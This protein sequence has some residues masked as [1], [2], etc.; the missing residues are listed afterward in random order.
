MCENTENGILK[1]IQTAY[2]QPIKWSALSVPDVEHMLLLTR[3]QV[4]VL[5]HYHTRLSA[6]ITNDTTTAAKKIIT[7]Q[8]RLPTVVQ[9]GHSRGEYYGI[10]WAGVGW[11]MSSEHV[12]VLR[13]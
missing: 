13:D 3:L 10:L 1:I 4:P 12:R 11:D 7:K 2:N 9:A 8:L 5:P 6:T